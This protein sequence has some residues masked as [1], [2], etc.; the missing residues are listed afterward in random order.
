[1]YVFYLHGL[2]RSPAREKMKLLRE[3]GWRMTAPQLDYRK[4]ENNPAMFDKLARMCADAQFDLILGSSYGGYMGFWLSE[5]CRIPAVL[6]NP[7]LHSRTIEVPAKESHTDT[8]KYLL[9]GINDNVIVPARTK[10]IISRLGLR[11]T[12]IAELDF[13]HSVP[14]DIFGKAIHYAEK[15]L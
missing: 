2:D 15:I 3:A 13:G 11:N 12:L 4:Y 8:C 10:T 5:Y 14:L 6:F 9:L 7:A 1:M